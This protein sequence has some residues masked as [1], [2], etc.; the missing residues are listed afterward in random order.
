M[1]QFS[2]MDCKNTSKQIL[3]NVPA[4][5]YLLIPKEFGGGHLAEPC[6]QGYGCFGGED[7]YEM[8]PQWNKEFIPEMIRRSKEGNWK[9]RIS[10]ITEQVLRNY[11][12]GRNLTDGFM[13][14][15]S[16][17]CC[18][19]L[20]WIGI[21]MACYDQDNEALPYPIKVTYDQDAVY[22]DCRPSPA[23]PDQGW[24]TG[25]EDED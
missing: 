22:E 7:V 2:W 3:G 13:E 19:E 17:Y 6:Y 20:R 11:Y 8:I 5:S 14:D 16:R 23:D 9:N 1:G 25:D 10:P 15:M 18:C 21:T 4:T 24:L 12:E